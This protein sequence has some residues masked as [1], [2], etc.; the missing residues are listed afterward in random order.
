MCD[1]YREHLFS[2]NKD[3]QPRE[4]TLERRERWSSVYS[5]CGSWRPHSW[6]TPAVTI[7]NFMLLELFSASWM[8]Q[9]KRNQ[10]LEGLADCLLDNMSVARTLL[11]TSIQLSEFVFLGN[12]LLWIK[13][14]GM[15]ILKAMEW[16]P[17]YPRPVSGSSRFHS[18]T[19]A[20]VPYRGNHGA[21][22]SPPRPPGLQ[23]PTPWPLSPVCHFVVLFCASG[24]S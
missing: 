23:N 6:P 2:L 18:M 22:P 13:A 21:A 15:A 9:G 8:S 3:P 17:C 24:T 14:Y 7:G 16:M 4:G 20:V 5:K 12:K 1:V 19:F 11:N 10:G